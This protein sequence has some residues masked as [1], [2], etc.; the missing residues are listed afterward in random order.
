MALET[1]DLALTLRGLDAEATPAASAAL[2]LP[3]FALTLVRLAPGARYE[4]LAEHA[5]T[6]LVLEGHGTIAIDDWRATLSGGQVLLWPARAELV[7]LA[8]GAQTLSLLVTA[9][10]PP[11]APS[12]S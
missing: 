6:V 8:D 9:P 12:S 2:D 5:A 11:A 7:A 10:A 1:R 3:G 4:R